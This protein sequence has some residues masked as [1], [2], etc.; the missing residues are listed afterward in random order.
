MPTREALAKARAAAERA[1]EIDD[2]LAEAHAS[3]A[4]TKFTGLDWSGAEEGYK[5][6]IELN[7]S[8]PTAH[9]WYALYLTGLGNFEGAPREIRRAQELDPLSLPINANVGF[10]LYAA[11]RHDEAAEQCRKTL[12]MDP[13]FALARTR[14][15]LAYEGKGMYREAIAEFRQAVAY[16]NR[17]P[18]ALAALAHAQAVSGE[19]GEAQKVLGELAGLSESRYVAPY[20]VALV[21]S[22]GSVRP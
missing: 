4:H 13:S 15:G 19:R 12:E 5:H 11:R 7:P 21:H 20:D 17:H 16:S 14:L 6:S 9:H 2:T 22:S 3:L 10:V 18:N 1:L 8:Y